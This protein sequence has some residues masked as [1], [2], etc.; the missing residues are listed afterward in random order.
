MQYVTAIMLLASGVTAN[1]E[2]DWSNDY[3][4]AKAHARE[5][6]RPLLVIM[7][8][9]GNEKTKF[10]DQRLAS[11]K[12]QIELM[13]KY[14]LCR[15]DVST[16]YGRRVAKAFK[17]SEFPYTAIT[18]KTTAYIAFRGAGQMEDGEWNE[19]LEEHVKGNLK[20]RVASRSNA[21][22]RNSQSSQ[23]QQPAGYQFYQPA[24]T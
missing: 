9:P 11:R 10:N 21:N 6:R 5:V 17:V 19:M 3:T 24:G 20:T 16:N 23:T 13:K 8:D 18:D 2:L 22:A 15:V 1:S 4:K 12:E 14:Q 7:E